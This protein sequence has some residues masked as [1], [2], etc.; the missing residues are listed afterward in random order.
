M[1]FSDKELDVLQLAVTTTIDVCDATIKS[2][3]EKKTDCSETEGIRSRLLILEE[4]LFNE[5][6]RQKQSM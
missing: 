2:C 6:L 5:Q 1:D 4:R 3:T